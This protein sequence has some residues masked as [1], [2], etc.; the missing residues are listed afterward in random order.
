MRHCP[1]CERNLPPDRF[2]NGRRICKDCVNAQRRQRK[3]QQREA[4]RLKAE[5]EAQ[6]MNFLICKPWRL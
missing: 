5:R 4:R 6:L 3:A 2:F 1:E